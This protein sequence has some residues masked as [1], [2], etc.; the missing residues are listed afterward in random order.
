MTIRA[1]LAVS[2]P[3]I[4]PMNDAMSPWIGLTPTS[5]LAATFRDGAPIGTLTNFGIDSDGIIS[6]AFSNGLV[7]TL[8]QVAIAT[9]T[10]NGGLVDNGN[11]LFS[12]GANSGSPVVTTA[13]TLGAGQFAGSSLELS[14]V[15]I[16][17]EF[18]KMI[19]AST[20][21]SASSRVIRTADEL[22]QQL[23]VLGR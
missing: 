9:F 2:P 21:Y 23:M 20:G 10:N 19:L 18:I 1:V 6:G 16:G 17:E 3:A 7:R 22:M 15:D 12:V 4:G 8:G 13:R 14:N 5:T 11:N